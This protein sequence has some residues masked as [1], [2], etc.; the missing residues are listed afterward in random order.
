MSDFHTGLSSSQPAETA[1][2]AAVIRQHRAGQ[3]FYH[4]AP[5]KLITLGR[6]SAATPAIPAKEP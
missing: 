4:W 1:L 6:P 3:S 2:Q 5:Y